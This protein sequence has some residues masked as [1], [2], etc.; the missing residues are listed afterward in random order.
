MMLAE[1]AMAMGAT[2]ADLDATFSSVCTDSRNNAEGSLFFALRGENSDG[3]RYVAD[4]LAGGAVAAVV[5]QPIHGTGAPQLVVRDSM[6]ALGDLAAAYRDRF[7]LPV[8]A[9]TGSVGKTS[10]REMIAVALRAR[11]NVLAGEKNFNNEIGVPL[12]LFG[13]SR[14]HAVALVEMGMRASGEIARLAEIARPTIAVITNV[15]LSHI[16]RLGSRDGIARAKAEL[17]E[18]LPDDGLAI[19]PADDDYSAFLQDTCRQRCRMLTFGYSQG[20]DYRVTS[21]SY[22]EAGH[23]AFVLNGQRI[24]LKAPGTHLP[25][26]AAAAAAIAAS[27]GMELKETAEALGEYRAPAMRMETVRTAAGITVLNDA[28]NA[29]PDSMRAALETLVLL[30]QGRRAIA[31]LGE[32]RELGE[33]G[34][35]AHRYVGRLVGNLPIGLLV[36]VGP[37]AEE[38]ARAAAETLPID[39]VQSFASTEDAAAALPGLLKP[40]DVVLIKGSRAMAMEKIVE[41]LAGMNGNERK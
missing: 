34:P 10:T 21:I 33:H 30:A 23:P 12:T 1:A 26:N 8:I 19:L 13:L 17:L 41:P 37:A 18:S 16:E 20:A 3:H 39:R 35:E 32:M 38:I 2:G 4:A 25:I 29:A 7:D 5:E 11:F 6:D 40:G 31:V 36:T 9:I 27:L 14:D 28:Y 15:G 22:N 24:E